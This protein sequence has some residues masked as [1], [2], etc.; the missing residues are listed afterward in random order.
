MIESTTIFLIIN[1]LNGA[2][3]SLISPLLPTL[4]EKDN[5]SESALGWIIGIFPLIESI[6]ST[7]V[8]IL[9]KKFSR[10]NLLC[11]GT[12]VTAIITILYG[13]LIFI[14]NINL[15]LIACF[16]LRIF[17]GL[18]A[19]IIT[20]LVYSLTISLAEKDKTQSSL[21][22]L[23]IVFSVGNSL[24]T[25]IASVFYKI[26]GYPL[27]F[28]V[29]GILLFFSFHLSSQVNDKNIKKEE[30]G[31]KNDDNINYL[32]Y[33]FYPQIYSILFGFVLSM[34][35]LTFYFPSLTYHLTND[36]MISVSTASLFF[37]LPKIPN[38]ISLQFLD[39]ISAKFGIYLTFTIAL[40]LTGMSSLFIYPIPPLPRSLIVVI[41]GFLLMGSGDAPA[42]IPGLVMLAKNI[43]GIDNSIDEMSA[44]DISSV[45]ANITVEL[46]DFIGPIF[47]GYLTDNFGFKLCCLII[48]V[49][50]L[51]Y[52]A[53]IFL[54][55][56]GYIK[57][58]LN[59]IDDKKEKSEKYESNK[60]D[61]N[62]KH[63]K[64]N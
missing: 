51:A 56:Y 35:S 61:E 4:G 46:G 14:P 44:N 36:Y 47:G 49:I 30:N 13:F 5:I 37:L 28:F 33:L 27:P 23:E 2:S 9:S 21:G 60:E 62:I 19:A 11:F 42:F 55:F 41:I 38:I 8:P 3:Y 52:S 15:L 31:E 39:K 64:I 34:V 25:L 57:I 63:S 32:K 20:T 16:A 48:S 12:F 26:G 29:T 50:G 45:L 22:K 43:K 53:I 18:C 10:V 58:D 40:T 7:M 17:H 1:M 54:F 6:F 59:K 24:G